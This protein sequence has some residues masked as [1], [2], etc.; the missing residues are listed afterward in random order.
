MPPTPDRQL[1]F[2]RDITMKNTIE[3]PISGQQISVP[4]ISTD[5]SQWTTAENTPRQLREEIDTV[6]KGIFGKEVQGLSPATYRLC[7]F[8]SLVPNNETLFL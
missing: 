3:H 6:M 5:R 4:L 7:W 8:A 1:K 2:I